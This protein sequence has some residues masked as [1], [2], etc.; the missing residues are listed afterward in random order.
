MAHLD[1]TEQRRIGD[2]PATVHAIIPLPAGHPLW[3]VFWNGVLSIPLSNA[4]YYRRSLVERLYYHNNKLYGYDD[5]RDTV[6]TIRIAPFGDPAINV[7]MDRQG[8]LLVTR[9]IEPGGELVRYR[10]R[11]IELLLDD[12]HPVHQ[13]TPAS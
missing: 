1:F 2:Q 12:S 8:R 13:Q 5:P 10:A 6:C 11:E 4:R 9:D 7:E 3:S